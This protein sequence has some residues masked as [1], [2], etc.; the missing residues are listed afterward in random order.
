MAQGRIVWTVGS[1]LMKGRQ[2]T[3]FNTKQPLLG[4]DGQPKME[5]GFGL[6][7][8]KIDPATGQ[9]SEEYVKVWQAMHAEAQALYAGAQIP[10]GFAMKFKDGDGVDAKTGKPY[11]SKEGYAG[12]IVLACTTSLPIKYFIFSGGNNELVNTGIKSGDYVNVQLNIKA[13]GSKNNGNPGLYLN[14]AAVQLI[15][16][17]APIIN[18]PS[19]DQMFGN[20]APA[21]AGQVIA[22]QGP[23]PMPGT[24]AP[25]QAPQ[26][27][28]PHYGV[29]PQTMQPGQVVP[30]APVHPAAPQPTASMSP[31][32]MNGHL[33]TSGYVAPAA[34]SNPAVQGQVAPAMPPM[35]G[36]Y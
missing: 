17:G 11:A 5:Y 6:A 21:Y 18:A 29:L 24:V 25:Q 13:H 22:D 36:Q 30:N 9:N 19:G 7:I 23:A 32:P 3:D 8:P 14:P 1:D 2:K 15:A 31:A 10:P 34:P 35:P 12:H 33:A 27:A 28:D 4:P 20:A 26:Q 16:P